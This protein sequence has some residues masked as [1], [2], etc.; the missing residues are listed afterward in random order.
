[1]MAAAEAKRDFKIAFAK[2]ELELK[3]NGMATTIL[4]EQTDGDPEIAEL[5]FKWDAAEIVAECTQEA[6]NV[7]KIELRGL[8]EEETREWS[9]T[10]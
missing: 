4:K 10:E 1:M 6:I 3:A 7:K 2:K 5:R 8:Q 9:L